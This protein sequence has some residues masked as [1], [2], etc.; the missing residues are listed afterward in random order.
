[1]DATFFQTGEFYAAA[2][3][4]L[5]AFA[6]VLFRRSGESIPPLALNLFKGA[7][8]LG[9]FLVTLPILGVPFFPPDRTVADWVT[10]G[11]SGILGIAVADT[12]FFESLNRLGAGRSAIVDCLYSPMVVL[13]SFVYL[14]EDMGPG[15][16]VGMALMSGAILVG[17]WQ[18]AEQAPT[19]QLRRSLRGG[20]ILGALSMLTMAVGIVLAKPILDR[21]DPWWATTVRLSAGVAVLTVQGMLP[22]HRASVLRA[23]RP[24]R[25]W[26]VAVPGAVIGAYA[27]LILWILGFKYAET[28]VAS[29]L[30]QLSTVFVL[31][32]ATLFLKEPL[33]RR[34]VAAIL[35]GFAG[36]LVVS[37]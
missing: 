2:T 33:T 5:W 11:A 10:L 16:W 8:G 26:R 23:F 3:A 32:L 25:A 1:M 20:V 29:V 6:V 14:R 31:V 34:K 21:S 9:L 4:L 7:V 24:N 19:E 30:N 17:A 35:M 22:R 13:C 15:L 28:T 37:L 12:L 18:P 27:A 36:G